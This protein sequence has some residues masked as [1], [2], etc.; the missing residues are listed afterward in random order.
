MKNR[1]ALRDLKSIK[2]LALISLGGALAGFFNGLLGAGGGIIVVLALSYAI[3]GDEEARRSLYANALC[4]MLPLSLLTLLT[5]A[6]RGGL[7]HGFL[8]G[9]YLWV[10]IGGALGGILGGVVLGKLRASLADGLF[11]LL[12][13]VSGV[14][15]LR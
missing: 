14:L 1:M 13:V 15:M 10:L 3:K 4:V 11:A 12:T 2:K 5:Y 6:L 9:D 8:G 7:P